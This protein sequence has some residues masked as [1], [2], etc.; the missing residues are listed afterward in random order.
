[1]FRRSVRYGDLTAKDMPLGGRSK[2]RPVG[3]GG[4]GG[5]AARNNGLGARGVSDHVTPRRSRFWLPWDGL[6]PTPGHPSCAGAM[7]S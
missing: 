4:L 2:G 7:W 5:R 1:V 3:S 6:E